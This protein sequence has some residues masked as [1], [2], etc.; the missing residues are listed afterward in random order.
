VGLIHGGKR[1]GKKSC[2]K[3]EKRLKAKP[4]GEAKSKDIRTQKSKKAGKAPYPRGKS[5]VQ[6][7][8]AGGD[9]GVLITKSRPNI[10]KI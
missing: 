5:E 8:K 7:E 10:N 2:H 4:L 9:L 6:R 1:G 3:G